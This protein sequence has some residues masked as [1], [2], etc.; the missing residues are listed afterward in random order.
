M[1]LGV[2]FFIRVIGLEL[3][4]FL[5]YLNKCSI[6]FVV[7]VYSIL[8]IIIVNDYLVLR[9]KY[10]FFITFFFVCGECISF[11]DFFLLIKG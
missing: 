8:F 3:Y 1:G 2:L 4:Y 10:I 5:R 6:Y 7:I 9:I 11:F